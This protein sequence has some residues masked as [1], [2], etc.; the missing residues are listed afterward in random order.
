MERGFDMAH[1][2]LEVSASHLRVHGEEQASAVRALLEND[3]RSW[4]DDG[5]LS[6]LISAYIEC[7]NTALATYTHMGNVITATGD[8]LTTAS[9]RVSY[10]EDDLVSGMVTLDGDAGAS[11][12]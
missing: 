3:P 10:V 5:L 9:G 8:G 6:P 1:G 11:W 12:T 7:K 2:A 4:G